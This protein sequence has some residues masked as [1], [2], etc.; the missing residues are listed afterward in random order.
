MAAAGD[1]NSAMDWGKPTTESDRAPK[2]AVNRQAT[3]GGLMHNTRD[4]LTTP[5]SRFFAL[6]RPAVHYNEVT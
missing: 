4:P 3:N 2:L 5:R 6:S 1:G